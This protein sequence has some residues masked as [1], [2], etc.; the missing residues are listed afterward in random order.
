MWRELLVRTRDLDHGETRVRV[1]K[2]CMPPAQQRQRLQRID[3]VEDIHPGA[4]IKSF[5]DGVAS[6]LQG[7]NLIV[8][9]Y[10]DVV[11]PP[12]GWVDPA[13]RARELRLFDVSA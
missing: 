7:A 8:A 13:D 2:R 11:D 4:R 12:A 6:F 9:R 5:A 3:A 10:G 1:L